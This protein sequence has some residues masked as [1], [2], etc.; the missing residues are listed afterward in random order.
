M[1]TA[2]FII[3][4][5]VWLIKALL[6]LKQ[7]LKVETRCRYALNILMNLRLLHTQVHNEKGATLS[8]LARKVKT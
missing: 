7:L 4:N 2:Y 8:K 1:V 6:R 3:S 5:N